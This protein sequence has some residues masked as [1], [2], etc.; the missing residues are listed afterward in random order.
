MK[1]DPQTT[2]RLQYEVAMR[3]RAAHIDGE[4]PLKRFNVAF[5]SAGLPEIVDF[6][7]L[8]MLINGDPMTAEMFQKGMEELISLVGLDVEDDETTLGEAVRK[9]GM[10]DVQVEALVEKRVGGK[11]EH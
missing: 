7:D 11:R 9:S 10:T 4:D 5:R 1:S 3:V 6:A 2:R 8:T